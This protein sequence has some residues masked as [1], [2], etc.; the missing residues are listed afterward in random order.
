MNKLIVSAAVCAAMTTGAFAQELNFG[1]APAP[2]SAESAKAERDRQ[3][4]EKLERRLAEKK[5]REER[6]RAE[7]EAYQKA[8]EDLAD[9]RAAERKGMTLED[10]R[11]KR[12]TDDANRAEVTLEVWRQMDKPA[13]FKALREANERRRLEEDTKKAEKA[14][15]S[16]EDYRL[17]R[18]A[19]NAECTLE[20]WKALDEAGRR[21]KK[22]EAD[23]R[24]FLKYEMRDAEKAGLTL[25]EFRAKRD[26]DR[27]AKQEAEAAERKALR[28]KISRDF[29][30]K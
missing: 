6:A 5:A 10:Y 9:Q 23:A 28:E 12:D 11:L 21:A 22:K 3:G 18:D 4:Q 25:E 19:K 27:K 2:S 20:E 14:G 29:D 16:V 15:L 13:R 24:T 17:Q 7:A 8:K 26:A 1:G 30:A